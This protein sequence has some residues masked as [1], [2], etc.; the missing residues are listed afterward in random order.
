MKPAWY[1]WIGLSLCSATT[2][3]ADA[4]GSFSDE[5]GKT[6]FA[7]ITLQGPRGNPDGPALF[8]LLSGPVHVGGGNETK[9]GTYPVPEPEDEIP[10]QGRGFLLDFTCNVAQKDR[11]WGSCTIRIFNSKGA[12]L[13]EA[14]QT[15]RFATSDPR[16]LDGI[17]AL[18]SVPRC[19][20]ISLVSS[21][22]RF[23]MSRAGGTFS[24]SYAWK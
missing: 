14:L 6:L 5:G 21:D 10:G 19:Q 12:V 8:E 22:S 1:I 18:F 23:K 9:V 15:I 4:L 11:D 20:E 2:G 24:I 16:E 17:S 7:T 13:D 3:H